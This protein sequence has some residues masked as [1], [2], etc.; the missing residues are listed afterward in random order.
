[1]T[2][3][4]LVLRLP[5]ELWC[6]IVIYSVQNDQESRS[7]LRAVSRAF[8]DTVDSISNLWTSIAFEQK[9][10][11][12]DLS[13]A[14]YLLPKSG[15]LPLSVKVTVPSD[16]D[17]DETLDLVRLLSLYV[18]RFHELWLIVPY[19]DY[20]PLLLTEIGESRPAPLLSSLRV[21]VDDDDDTLTDW[22]SPDAID[23]RN[24]FH[25]A[26]RLRV[27]EIPSTFVPMRRAIPFFSSTPT[28]VVD[29]NQFGSYLRVSRLAHL[30][31]R[32]PRLTEFVYRCEFTHPISILEQIPAIFAPRLTSAWVNV[33][34][35]GLDILC[36]LRAPRLNTLTLCGIPELDLDPSIYPM[37]EYMSF[38][39]LRDIRRLAGNFR[40]LTRLDLISIKLP[41]ADA[42]YPW[43][44]GGG[45][46]SLKMLFIGCSAI[47]DEV[48]ASC[49]PRNL[50]TLE[51]FGCLEVTGIGLLA[52]ASECEED[53][54]LS[55]TMCPGVSRGDL[56]IISQLI[57]VV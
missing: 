38:Y 17:P 12:T 8:R 10:N 29:A 30:I 34:G 3:D 20:A 56:D 41:M 2:S 16:V 18:S 45:F 37:Q 47:A 21:S 42:S 35:G 1:M 46:P 19:H 5:V 33:P 50:K 51:L 6:T 40:S 26:P 4:N 28:L 53:F 9:V 31:S 49:R 32:M 14:R 22:D 57:K 15:I 13:R 25:P 54:Q 48:L 36:R 24:I 44:F 43:L 23:L 11:F 52:F 7:V 27:V 55:V 39:L